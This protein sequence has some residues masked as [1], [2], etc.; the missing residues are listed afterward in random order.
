MSSVTRVPEGATEFVS[1]EEYLSTSYEPGVEYVHGKLEEPVMVQTVHGRLQGWI[2]SW[3]FTH[4]HE[5]KVDAGVEI[6]TNVASGVYRLPDVVV[7]YAGS[8]DPILSKPP[9][10]VI[11][12]LSLDDRHRKMLQKGREYSA[13]GIENIW[14]IDPGTRIVQRWQENAFVIVSDADLKVKDGPIY[15]D[16]RAMFA[17]LDEIQGPA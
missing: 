12:L 5:W 9:L 2:C 14:L 3:F 16:L 6:H 4:R 13:M 15:L 11:E 7:G 17:Y 8:W 10:I 1:E